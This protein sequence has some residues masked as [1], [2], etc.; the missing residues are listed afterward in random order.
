VAVSRF[1]PQLKSSPLRDQVVFIG[2]PVGRDE[3]RLLLRSEQ[4]P[5]R[6][7]RVLRDVYL[8]SEPDTVQWILQEG[9]DQTGFRAYLGY[10]G[11]AP[12]QLE[13]ELARGDWS[14]GEG[15]ADLIFEVAPGGL[16]QQLDRALGGQWVRRRDAPGGR[17]G[18]GE[19]S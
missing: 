6:A 9:S 11:W 5:P 13:A 7:A 10:A 8:A 15:S 17:S 1:L 4:G 19:M 12:G 14:L 18:V 3:L 2:G 16:W